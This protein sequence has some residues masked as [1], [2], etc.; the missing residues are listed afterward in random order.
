MGTVYPFKTQGELEQQVIKRM[1]RANPDMNSVH[2]KLPPEHLIVRVK[3]ISGRTYRAF[4]VGTQWF[5]SNT[6]VTHWIEDDREREEPEDKPK[7]FGTICC[8]CHQSIC[9]CK[10][11]DRRIFWKTIKTGLLIGIFI[12]TLFL[13]LTKG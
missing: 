5:Q 1:K 13:L 6:I 9:T 8:G 10:E 11:D 4:R 3:D 2:D 12:V 7:G